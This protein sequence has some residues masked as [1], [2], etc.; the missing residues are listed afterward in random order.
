MAV[1]ILGQK[2]YLAG[3]RSERGERMIVATNQLPKNAIPIYLRRWEIEM[4]FQS[5][6]GRGF[7][8][9]ETRLPHYERFEKLILLLVIGF[10]WAHKVGEWHAINKPISFYSL[11]TSLRLT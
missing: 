11:I 2:V 9:E 8:F 10:C 4:L 3:S 1:W 5:L 7:C 6:K